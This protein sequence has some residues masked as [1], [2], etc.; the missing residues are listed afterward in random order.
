MMKE[1]NMNKYGLVGE[2]LGHSLSPIIHSYILNKIGIDGEYKLYEIPEEKSIVEELKKEQVVGFNVTIP[3]KEKIM[4]ELDHISE[5]ALKIGAVNLV[6]IE[7]G[8]SC[9]YNSDY[10]GVVRMLE[11]YDVDIKNKIC[12][13]LGSGGAAKSVIV[14][15]Q[16]LGAKEIVV[17]TRDVKNKRERLREKFKNI[18]INSYDDIIG[19]DI[20]IN[21]TPCGMYPDIENTPVTEEII[22]RFDIAVD[23]IYNPKKTKFLTLAEKN[24]LK[25]VN[26]TIML[27]EQAIKSEELWQN[28]EIKREVEEEIEKILDERLEVNR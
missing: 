18:E 5:E 1:E 7:D 23:V 19:G 14:A 10:F 17:I 26:G 2:K 28:M 15:L 24:G 25:S 8:K 22:K 27:I 12:Y 3:Y 4:K 9:G 16:D 21:T 13:V 11:K 6:K 20:I